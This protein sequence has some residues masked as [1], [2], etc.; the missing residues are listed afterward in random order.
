MSGTSLDGIDVAIIDLQNNADVELIAAQT[1]AFDPGLK[2][3]LETLIERQQC[4]LRKFG[5]LDITMGQAIASATARRQRYIKRARSH[6]KRPS[7]I[8]SDGRICRGRRG[9]S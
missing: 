7:G 6:A 1:Y 8:L 3:D 4:D 5:E 9:Q 2:Q